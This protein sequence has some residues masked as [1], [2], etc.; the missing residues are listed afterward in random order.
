M[1]NTNPNIRK[2]IVTHFN[3]GIFFN[4]T[5][6]KITSVRA[7]EKKF[8]STKIVF[9]LKESPFKFKNN[10]QLVQVVKLKIFLGT[11]LF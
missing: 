4:N 10:R 1:K 11:M 2:V 7:L 3:L 6:N 8:F 9:V 5:V